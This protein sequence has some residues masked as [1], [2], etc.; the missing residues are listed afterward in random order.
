MSLPYK[1]CEKCDSAYTGNVC[2]K[3]GHF[4]DASHN[5]N[6]LDD[7]AQKS[8]NFG[9]LTSAINESR[10]KLSADLRSVKQKKRGFFFPLFLGMVLLGIGGYAYFRFIYFTPE[11]IS[12]AVLSAQITKKPGE[13]VNEVVEI[14]D[15]KEKSIPLDIG[16]EE[17]NF[18]Q[19]DFAQFASP[20]TS[21][22]ITAFNIR[23]V[24]SKYYEDKGIL[25]NLKSEF[26]LSDNDIDVFF[27]KGFSVYFPDSDFSK[28]GFA[29]YV[30]D[31]N[32]VD[33]RVSKLKD[34]KEKKGFVFKDYFA[35]V[36][37]IKSDD[38]KS[39]HFLLI[40]N[41]KE[42]LDQMKESSEGNLTNLAV[43]IKYT[44]VKT[45]LPKLGQ[46]SFYR[47][48][49]SSIWNLMV[50]WIAS[51]Y[52]YVGLDKILSAIDAPG[53]VFFSNSQKLKITTADVM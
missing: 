8:E 50:E 2:L 39:I 37:E 34:K 53:I 32:F 18:D 20:D 33:S 48:I 41:S 15:S 46:V 9:F 4:E 25:K 3:C 28:W 51:K 10:S 23:D 29:I 30:E 40:S 12:P 6:R 22:L 44:R 17:G 7:T 31:Q 13:V 36:V 5:D 26:D 21:L 1:I 47:K 49:D 42:Y 27:S 45:D 16:H 11:Y 52:D 43:D 38:E 24:L 19:Y 14:S 35:D